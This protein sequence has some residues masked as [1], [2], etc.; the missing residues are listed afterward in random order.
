MHIGEISK[1]SGNGG[2]DDGFREGSTASC[3]ISRVSPR[4]R[5]NNPTGK[6]SLNPSRLGKYSISSQSGR[7]PFA[8]A[9]GSA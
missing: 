5:Q 1:E 4:L 2:K 6:I 8:A 3:G 7:N 9:G